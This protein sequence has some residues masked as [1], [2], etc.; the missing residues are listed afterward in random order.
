MTQPDRK[1]LRA[2]LDEGFRAHSNGHIESA[3]EAY[4]RA[5]TIAPDHP[6][7]LNL[8][9]VASLQLGDAGQAVSYLER[10]VANRR[11]DPGALGNL[12]QAYFALG[13]YE[14]AEEA[15]RKAS[16]IDSRNVYFQMGVA[17]SIAA[18]GDLGG[19]EIMLRRLADRFPATALVWFNLGNALR[20]QNR[21]EDALPCYRKA[22]ELDPQQADAHN[23]L[24][25]AL[26][27]LHRFDEAEVEYRA[28]IDMAPEYLPAR[29]NL[30]SVVI[31]AGR[32]RD[33]EE[34]CRELTRRDP[35]AVQPYI[36]LAVALGQQ[37]PLLREK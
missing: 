1:L 15:F 5:L 21:L 27:G 31:D 12:A 3:R 35:D 24:G 26:H 36:F 7:A 23:N 22:L 18:R 30:A 9:G 17:N 13:R 28:C 6:D 32:S 37:G 11:N 14:Q 4:A 34:L 25:S 29:Y 10:A 33:A 8:I 19:A 2:I 20:E 16:R